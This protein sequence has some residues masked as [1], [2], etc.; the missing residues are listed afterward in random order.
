[1]SS[2]ILV[3]DDDLLNRNILADYLKEGGF[4]VLL[5]ENG[6]EALDLLHQNPI[7]AVLLDLMMPKVNG[8]EVLAHMQ[9]QKQL[10][11]IPV[12]VIS[13]IDNVTSINR[14]LE[15]GAIDY[16]PKPFNPILTRVRLNAALV[17]SRLA[18][19]TEEL[20]ARND[21]L[22]A[23]ASTVAHDLKTPLTSIIGAIGL[24]KQKDSPATATHKEKLLNSIQ[25]NSNRMQE[26]IDALL[27]LATL[28]KDTVSLTP[29]NMAEI[30]IDVLGQLE[31]MTTKHNAIIHLPDNWP[32]AIGYAP[33]VAAIWSNYIGNAIKYGGEPPIITL[34]ATP[35]IDTVRFWVKDNGHG[36]APEDQ[37]ELFVPFTRLKKVNAEGQGLGLSIVQRIVLKLNGQAGLESTVGEG[38]TFWFTLPN[39]I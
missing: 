22:D 1:M 36:I 19:K 29:L 34:G 9:D 33:W 26:T 11:Q 30:I 25:N 28:G 13:S 18:R 5:A 35:Q 38:S 10:Q 37:N 39:I 14:C 32:S 4:D 27:L 24:L 31:A 6:Q 16:L 20:E 17:H 21:E 23:F 15:L 12:I 3:A 8:Y 7:N 2:L